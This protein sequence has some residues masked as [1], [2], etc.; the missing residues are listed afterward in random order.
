VIAALLVAIAD[1]KIACLRVHSSW[2]EQSNEWPS[3][4]AIGSTL[5]SEFAADLLQVQRDEIFD[6]RF[7]CSFGK[8]P[9]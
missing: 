2:C 5:A 7:D 4:P 1:H 6:A 3:D 8:A 9:R